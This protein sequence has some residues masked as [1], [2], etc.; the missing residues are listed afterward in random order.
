M[1]IFFRTWNY[2]TLRGVQNQAHTIKACISPMA[3]ITKLEECHRRVH[4]GLNKFWKYFDIY[5]NNQPLGTLWFMKQAFVKGR[6]DKGSEAAQ[7]CV[8]FL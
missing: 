3:T 5:H 8:V 6:A 1:A 2:L 4:W 7:K